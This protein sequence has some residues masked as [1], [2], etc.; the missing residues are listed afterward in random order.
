[1]NVWKYTY[2]Q[3]FKIRR[4]VIGKD[5]AD[6]YAAMLF[7]ALLD[8]L[9][10]WGVMTFADSFTGYHL[11]PGHEILHTVLFLGGAV[12]IERVHNR[13]LY[14][15]DAFLRI[16][17]EVEA[18]PRKTLW[19]ILSLLYILSAFAFFA[20]SLYCSVNKLVPVLIPL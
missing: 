5:G 4:R 16:R 7:V 19:G 18:E 1:M 14:K 13:T 6:D 11:L 12:I 2:I 10:Y 17:K 3:F 15:G 20:L 8:C 9:F